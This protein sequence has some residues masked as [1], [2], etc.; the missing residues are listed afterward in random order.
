MK[1]LKV[2]VLTLSI[3][4]LVAAC[5]PAQEESTAEIGSEPGTGIETEIIGVSWLWEQFDDTAD[6]NNIAVN[7][8]SLYTL[9]LNPDGTYEIKADCNL[10]SGRYT[11]EDS[12]ISFEPGPTTLAACEPGSLYDIYLTRLDEVATFVMD[13]D[14]LVLNLWADAGNMVFTPVQQ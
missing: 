4:L 2:A 5:S 3:A 8:P 11:L 10:A 6:I 14:N 13:G 9:L 7:D 1:A 12:L